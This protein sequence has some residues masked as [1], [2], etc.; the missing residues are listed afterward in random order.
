MAASGQTV[1]MAEIRSMTLG[2]GWAAHHQLGRL[3]LHISQQIEP[4]VSQQLRRTRDSRV[5]PNEVRCDTF[6]DG[7]FGNHWNAHLPGGECLPRFIP[8]IGWLVFGSPANGCRDFGVPLISSLVGVRCRS[9]LVLVPSRSIGTGPEHLPVLAQRLLIKTPGRDTVV[10]QPKCSSLGIYACH[11]GQ[12]ARHHLSCHGRSPRA[13]ESPVAAR[14]GSSA[15]LDATAIW[16]SDHRSWWWFTTGC[17]L[18][19]PLAASRLRPAGLSLAPVGTRRHITAHRRDDAPDSVAG[20]P[21]L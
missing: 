6:A 9:P 14:R 2:E 18:G 12:S 21:G 7:S 8:E 19:T 20:V 1:H 17:R 11:N 15:R 13:V 5:A 10:I 4:Q 16:R 3:A